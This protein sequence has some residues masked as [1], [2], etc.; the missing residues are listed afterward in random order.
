[1]I[2]NFRYSLHIHILLTEVRLSLRRK[3]SKD[4][5]DERLQ[6][7][8]FS[9]IYPRVYIHYPMTI[10]SLTGIICSEILCFPVSVHVGT[11]F[12]YVNRY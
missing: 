9:G 11:H 1:M 10:I 8:G 4:F 5:I 7:Y 3:Y 2:C 12:V 6:M